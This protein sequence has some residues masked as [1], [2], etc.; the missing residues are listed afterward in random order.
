MPTQGDEGQIVVSRE[1]DREHTQPYHSI[2]TDI[3][4]RIRYLAAEQRWFVCLER[5]KKYC[6]R[7]GGG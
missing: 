4:K 7:D 3:N 5:F 6:S 2:R 1:D